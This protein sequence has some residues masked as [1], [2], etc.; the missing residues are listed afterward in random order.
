MQLSLV[1]TKIHRFVEYI[2]EKNFNI[3]VHSAVDTRQSDENP[4]SSVVVETMKLSSQQLL[5][6]TDHRLEPK[7][8]KEV[9][10]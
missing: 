8:C 4:G 3:F 5:L 6:L 2:P 7:H 10:H 1:C 9:P